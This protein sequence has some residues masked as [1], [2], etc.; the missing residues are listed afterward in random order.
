MVNHTD[1]PAIVNETFTLRCEVNGSVDRIQWWRNGHLI[2]PN[3]TI[4][5]DMNNK[6]MT[7]DPVQHSDNGY[8]QCQAFNAVSNMTSS[9]YH[10]EVNC[11]YFF[12]FCHHCL[13]EGLDETA[14]VVTSSR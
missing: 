10:L 1:G 2:Y 13:Q 12:I 6:T 3:D 14:N 4:V 7:F 11:K 5:F 8:Y 9:P